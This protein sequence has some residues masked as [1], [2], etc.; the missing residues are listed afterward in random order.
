MLVKQTQKM[1][2]QATLLT[3]ILF[4]ILPMHIQ[5]LDPAL[6][7][8]QKA[9]K[10][11]KVSADGTGQFKT[12]T[13]ALATVPMK[14]T[15]RT[16]IQIAPGT[17]KEKIQIDREKPFIT[18]YGT[19]PTNLA[20]IT[21]DGTAL[22]YG[23]LQSATV[24]VDSDYFMAVNIVFENTAPE[25]DGKMKLAQAVAMRISG[26]KAA[27]Y[28]CRFLGFQDTLCD[29]RGSHYFENCFIQGTTDFIFGRGKSIYSQ[30]EIHSIDKIGGV[31][32]AH[33][34]EKQD[35][36]SAYI[37]LNCKVTGTGKTVLGRVWKPMARVIFA[38]SDLGAN[39]NPIGW[40]KMNPS[41]A[42]TMF[43]GEYKNTGPGASSSQRAPF[44]K[45][46]TEAE[47]KPFIDKTY[48]N[49]AAWLLPPPA[50]V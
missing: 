4:L 30:T 40:E 27:F 28:N 44:A 6:E 13:E 49:A 26:E 20:K 42:N 46:L 5:S 7:A 47:A 35:D 10:I 1:A 2:I 32:T 11:I 24:G 15:V 21:F 38:L 9:P 16:I 25:P 18:L 43:Y 41:Q 39:V 48:I 50:K 33:A 34:R 12:V 3:T 19:D 22:K 14:N 17:Y 23:T 8:A 29:D 31:I 37:F 45:Q 36:D